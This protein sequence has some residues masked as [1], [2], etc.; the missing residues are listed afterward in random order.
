LPFEYR[1][2]LLSQEQRIQAKRAQAVAELE[3][4]RVSEDAYLVNEA[5]DTILRCD[6]DMARLHQIAN[7][8]VSRQQHAQLTNRFHLSETEREVA[9]AALP[10]RPDMPKLSADDKHR[11]YSENRA[12][13]NRMRQTREYD[14]T[15][16]RVFR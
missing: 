9:E 14:D 16:G 5:A 3:S 1:D 12:R 7:E 4:G 13:L 11:I 15:Q 10:N 2:I 6:A 8:Y